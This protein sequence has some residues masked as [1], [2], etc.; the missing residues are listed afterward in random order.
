MNQTYLQPYEPTWPAE[1]LTQAFFK[2]RVE[3]LMQDWAADRTY[4]FLIFHNDR[5][6]GGINV[7]NVSRGAAQFA[8]LGYWLD[9][10]SQG[11]GYMGEAANAVLHFSF[12]HLA[13]Y[14][15]NAATLPHNRR[16][17]VMLERLGFREEGF[18]KAYIQINGRRQD[19]ILYG[20]NDSDFS[21]AS[22]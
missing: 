2:R 20:L 19:H 22:G 17:R 18:A 11:H 21:G 10:M 13:L 8:S 16:S 1:S 6:I 5:L 12:E 14:R 9:E 15:V 4:A 3:R 7:N